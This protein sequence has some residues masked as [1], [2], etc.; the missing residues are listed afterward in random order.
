[1]STKLIELNINKGNKW[2]NKSIM[3]ANIPEEILIVMIKRKGEVL[4]PKGA[5]VIEEGD[6]LV[7]SG[8]NIEELIDKELQKSPK[9]KTS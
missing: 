2:V 7:L 5:T 9:E 6:I 4:I 3:D 1:M 8:E